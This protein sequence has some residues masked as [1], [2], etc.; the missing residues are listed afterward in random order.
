MKS[1]YITFLNEDIR[2]GYKIKIHSQ[3]KALSE[4]GYE[5]YL[6]VV[7]KYGMALYRI[8]EKETLER[9][10]EIDR[11]R[12]SEERNITDEFFLI[13]YFVKKL[14]EM[15]QELEPELVYIRRIVP[16]NPWVFR[17]IKRMK[18]RNIKVIY[19]Y[20]S[21]P[22][23]KEMLKS[24]QILFYLL[25]NIYF[26]RLVRTIDVLA[27]MGN[28]DG[29]N[30]KFVEIKNGID[31]TAF[32]LHKKRKGK[33]LALI[34]V[35]HVAYYHGY[36][37]VIQGLSDYYKNN[38]KREVV[39][40]IV[41]PVEAGLKLEEQVKKCGL[42]DK[43]F[44]YG[45]KVGQELDAIFEK[46]D[47]GIECLG[48]FRRDNTRTGSLKGREYLA[49]GL[50]FLTCGE[51]DI[52]VDGMDFVFREDETESGINIK[53]LLG[54]YDAMRSTPKDIREFAR[55]RLSWRDQMKKVVE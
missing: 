14:W 10:F 1:L 3:C 11:R 28:Y 37:R 17:M 13:Q 45:F 30:R 21:Y 34:G 27:W 24:K 55:Q 46:S 31:V 48:L 52:E 32:P 22:W 19:E 49:R 44:F 35:A 36:D 2:P 33:E 43:V 6:F 4:L 9:K 50:P 53:N 5:S 42:Q 47:I 25:D 20:P 16:M 54:Q 38:P 12:K 23:K 7:K 40:H 8:G 29:D 18:K 15:V 51:P 41:G 39:F 26:K